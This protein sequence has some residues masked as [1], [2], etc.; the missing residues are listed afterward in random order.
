M[1]TYSYELW[2]GI[3]RH[4][5][6]EKRI[7][8][9]SS[10]HSN[11]LLVC[12]PEWV[13]ALTKGGEVTSE[14]QHECLGISLTYSASDAGDYGESPVSWSDILDR[15]LAA[16][17]QLDAGYVEAL[18]AEFYEEHPEKMPTPRTLH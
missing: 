5:D 18:L 2:T 3:I 15:K 17:W 16:E 12:N 6:T 8:V 14:A 1:N 13:S 11:Y 9:L 10:E 4:E 7:I